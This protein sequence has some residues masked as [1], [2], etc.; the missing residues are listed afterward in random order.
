MFYDTFE[1]LCRGKKVA[2]SAVARKL[3]MSTSAP[4]RW[5]GGS[6]P[7]LDTA[8]KIADYF[9]VTIDYLVA[10][11]PA[12]LSYVGGSINGH[13][14]VAGTTGGQISIN[15]SSDLNA[16]E[17]ELLRI[18]RGLDMRGQTA[19]LSAAYDHEELQKRRKEE[20]RS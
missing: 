8:Q 14:V 9:G 15:S 6:L 1:A 7:D 3:G 19:V 11:H 5:K 16:S 18:F 2:P 20:N 10:D 17:L 13:N 12:P 4:G